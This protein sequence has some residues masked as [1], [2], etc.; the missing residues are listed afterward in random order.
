MRWPDATNSGWSLSTLRAGSD[1]SEGMDETKLRAALKR[2]WEHMA[3]DA[4]TAH[5]FYQ[6]RAP[7][8][9][10]WLDENGTDA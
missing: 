9:A 2:Y 3:T 6:W 4:E 8:R 5:E 7:C 1:R 10:P